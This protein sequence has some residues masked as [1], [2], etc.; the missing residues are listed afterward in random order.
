TRE[1]HDVLLTM[2]AA[3][4]DEEIDRG[5]TLTGPHRDDMEI[6]LHDF[7]AKGYASHGESWSLALALRL[8]SYDLLR[9]EE[10]DL[11]DGEP[12]LILDDVFSELDTRRRE[13]LGRIVTGA[14]Q[15][16]ITTA[17]D[18]DIPD[19]LDGEIHVVEV[20]LGSAVPRDEGSAVRGAGSRRRSPERI[21]SACRRWPTPTTCP[22]GRRSGRVREPVA[23]SRRTRIVVGPSAMVRPLLGRRGPAPPPRGTA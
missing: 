11:G 14:S 15:V 17:N 3:R 4:H 5:A 21:A 6:R 7:P 19:T 22:P 18:T 2:L 10:G 20:S 8:A 16:L 12:I 13:R 1:I 9:L 23:Q